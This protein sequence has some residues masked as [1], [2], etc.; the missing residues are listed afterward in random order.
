MF[1]SRNKS[2]FRCL[3]L[4]SGKPC[5][6]PDKTV[7]ALGTFDGVHIGHRELLLKAVEVTKDRCRIGEN[8]RSGVFCFSFPPMDILSEDPPKHITTL[9]QKLSYMAELGVEV[10]FVADFLGMR[11]MSAA[12]FI[13]FLISELSSASV[14]CGFNFRFARRGE[15]NAAL[16]MEKFGENAFVIQPVLYGDEPCSSSRIR[17][18]IAGGDMKSAAEMLGRPFSVVGKVIHGK[19]LGREMGIP[20]I[21]IAFSEKSVIPRLGIYVS[22]VSVDGAEYA[23]VSNIGKRPSVENTNVPNCETHI[24]DYNGDLYGREATVKLYKFLRDEEKFSS[25][26]K[27]RS[28]ILS[29]EQAARKYFESL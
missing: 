12:D 27:L 2:L 19:H 8:T 5:P 17:T 26:E 4:Q 13:D 29:D 9:D 20:T 6:I 18:A 10:A 7:L 28:A 1:N 24:L 14:V 15:G 16:L 22:S 21:N 25:I 23:A 11:D 3:D